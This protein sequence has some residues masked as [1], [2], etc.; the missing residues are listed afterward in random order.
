MNNTK[1]DFEKRKEEINTYF[2]FLEIID[3][4]ENTRLKYKVNNGIEENRIPDK[5]QEILIAN[6]FLILYNLIEATIR[7]SIIEIFNSIREESVSFEQLSEKMKRVWIKQSSNKF[8]EGSFRSET[9]RE[10]LYDISTD[11]L[12][13]EIILLDKN[14]I[15][16]SG[17]LDAREIRKLAD[18]F[19]FEQTTNGRN[20][21]TIKEKRNRLAHGEHTF[22]D[23]GKDF[24]VNQ[25]ITFK[26]ESFEYLQDTINKIETYISNKNYTL[27]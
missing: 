6:G 20:L 26:T 24:T 11:I 25:L 12:N 2:S 7:N 14:S 10:Y 9:L 19:G 17:N 15:D 18:S 8:K 13:R 1:I 3:D 5:L 22:Y 16:F 4:D 27:N 23:I 21:L